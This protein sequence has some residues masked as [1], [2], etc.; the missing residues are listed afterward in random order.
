[1]RVIGIIAAVLVVVFGLAAAVTFVVFPRVSVAEKGNVPRT[2]DAA[3][4]GLYLANYVMGCIDCHSRREEDLYS[5]PPIRSAEF[6][7]GFVFSRAM[8]FPGNIVTPN[9]T[10][11][12]LEDWT[13]GEVVR[14][15]A[16][17][18]S[19][20]GRPLFPLMP[21]HNFGTLDKED[22]EAVVA[23]LRLVPAVRRA[24]PE[25]TI[26]FPVN[27]LI[28]FMPK[29]PVFRMRPN[30]REAVAYGEYMVRAAGCAECHTV[31]DARGNPAG[32][33][34]AG[35]MEMLHPGRFLVRPTNITPDVET[36]IGAWTRE[37]FIDRFKAKT[38]EDYRNTPA[39]RGSRNTLMPWWAFAGMTREDLGA[40]YDYL[41][42][43]PAVRN[44][45]V[46]FE[47]R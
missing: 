30:P 42:T 37:Q 24:V 14:A 33:P 11:G 26:D 16:A 22:I 8:G 27:V 36:G 43:V 15:I 2:T 13:D 5:M 46:T 7:G 21:Y 10:Q 23:Y 47:P 28:R 41:R 31:L 45:V 40:I 39:Q 6:G 20:D 35:G 1:M 19:R 18:V 3:R 12:A 32:P 9:I 38:E 17:G 34:F 4:R 44:E 25:T 29:D